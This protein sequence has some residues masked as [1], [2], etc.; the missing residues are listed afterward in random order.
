MTA[1]PLRLRSINSPSIS[2]SWTGIEAVGN[3]SERRLSRPDGMFVFCHASPLQRLQGQV[4]PCCPSTDKSVCATPPAHVS[5][6]RER[7]WLRRPDEL[8]P[9]LRYG[10]LVWHRHSCLCW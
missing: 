5:R 3:R 6:A 1:A 8:N 4:L 2:E 10:R 9:L 7:L